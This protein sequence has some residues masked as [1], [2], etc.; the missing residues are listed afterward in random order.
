MSQAF[1]IEVGIKKYITFNLEDRDKKY[2]NK[3]L[4][5]EFYY[6]VC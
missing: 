2:I 6:R 1:H 4:K 5:M 3:D